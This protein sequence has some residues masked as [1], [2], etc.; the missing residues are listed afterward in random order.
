M[1]GRAYKIRKAKMAAKEDEA[2]MA[3]MSALLGNE[4]ETTLLELHRNN[5]AAVLVDTLDNAGD[6]VDD[7]E[8]GEQTYR[9]A[10]ICVEINH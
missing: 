5:I 6:G 2:A 8:L 7:A 4:S 9:L 10:L 3:N 1:V